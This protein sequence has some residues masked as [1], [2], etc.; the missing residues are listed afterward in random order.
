MTD[1]V[2]SYVNLG[3][4]EAEGG[5]GGNESIVANLTEAGGGGGAGRIGLN[6]DSIFDESVSG[7]VQRIVAVEQPSITGLRLE[8][9]T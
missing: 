9:P 6:E 4:E 8:L 3:F 7:V 2:Q 1:G 5:G